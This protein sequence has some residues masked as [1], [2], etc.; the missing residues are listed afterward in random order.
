MTARSDALASQFEEALADL[1]ATIEACPEAQWSALCGDERWTVAAAAQHVGAQFGIERE[2]ITG[3]AGLAPMPQVGW[4]EINATNEQ[5]AQQFSACTREEAMK[6]LKQDGPK[7]AALV[8]GLTDEQLDRSVAFPLAGG[9]SV[10]TQQIIEGGVLI[11][12]VRAHLKS[13]RAAG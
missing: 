3:T 5:R 1:I 8:R 11:D 4:D 13:I 9:A 7:M 10:T 2:L 12:H 6:L